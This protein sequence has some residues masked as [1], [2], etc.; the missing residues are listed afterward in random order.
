MPISR[1]DSPETDIRGFPV[2]GGWLSEAM[3]RNMSVHNG[4]KYRGAANPDAN[5]NPDPDTGYTR[6]LGRG[7][8]RVFPLGKVFV[9]R[10]QIDTQT[11][12]LDENT[13][14]TSYYVLLHGSPAP[15]HNCWCLSFKRIKPSPGHFSRLLRAGGVRPLN[16]RRAHQVNHI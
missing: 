13:F 12:I 14:W 2:A 9:G 6:T 8:C 3:P 15:K 1:D 4:G 11:P 16:S 10:A 5:P 7:R